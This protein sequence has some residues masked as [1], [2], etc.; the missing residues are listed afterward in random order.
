MENNYG[1]GIGLG[2]KN[3]LNF[4]N[5]IKRPYYL[6]EWVYESYSFI[7]TSKGCNNQIIIKATDLNHNITF[8]CRNLMQRDIEETIK[9]GNLVR[10]AIKA[11]KG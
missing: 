2:M 5:S 9:Y 6:A 4:L 11:Y 8:T 3:I 10:A 7:C 1:I